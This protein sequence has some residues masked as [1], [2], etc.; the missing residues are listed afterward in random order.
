MI[1][2]TTCRAQ[3]PKDFRSDIFI[4]NDS[5]WSFLTFVFFFFLSQTS[6][7]F[8]LFIVE[9]GVEGINFVTFNLFILV[10]LSM[11]SEESEPKIEGKKTKA[12]KK[13]SRLNFK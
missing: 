1:F 8:H 3:S 11:L 7:D 13:H 4:I 9:S 5:L 2:V 6:I 10:F 12:W